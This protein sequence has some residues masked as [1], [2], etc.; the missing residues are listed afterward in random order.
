MLTIKEAVEFNRLVIK[1]KILCF[2]PAVVL[3]VGMIKAKFNELVKYTSPSISPMIAAG[4]VIKTLDPQCKVVFIGPCVA[5][6]LKQIEDLKGI[7][8]YVLTF[9][10]LKD[11]FDVLSI[12]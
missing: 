3:W 8:D 4:K 7:I 12:N 10:E 5:K 9:N 1:E 2:P 6:K 11:I